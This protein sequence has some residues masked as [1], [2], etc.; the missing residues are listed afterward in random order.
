MLLRVSRS[1]RLPRGSGLPNTCSVPAAGSS[2]PVSAASSVDLPLPEGPSTA[3]M[4]PRGT[5]SETSRRIA[6]PPRSMRTPDNC[7]R[8]DSEDAIATFNE[9]TT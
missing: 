9:N 6:R 4:L 5:L 7:T 3:V 1:A 2:S 8:F